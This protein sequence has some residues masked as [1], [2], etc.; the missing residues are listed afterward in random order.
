MMKGRRVLFA[1]LALIFALSM[2]LSIVM[3]LMTFFDGGKKITLEDK[4]TPQLSIDLEEL[5]SQNA[6]IRRKFEI[7]SFQKDEDGKKVFEIFS[8]KQVEDINTS[9]KNG[10]V[11]SLNTKETLFLLYDTIELFYKNDIIRITDVNGTTHEFFGVSHY[12]SSEYFDNFGGL[13]VG[14]VDMSYDINED[15]Y[16]TVKTRVE[17]LCSSFQ[18]YLDTTYLILNATRELEADELDLLC[19]RIEMIDFGWVPELEEKYA[20]LSRMPLDGFRFSN[21]RIDFFHSITQELPAVHEAFPTGSAPYEAGRYKYDRIGKVVVIEVYR[22]WSE[23]LVARIR[24]DSKND[25]DIVNEL[26]ALIKNERP[27]FERIS[28]DMP[29]LIANYRIAVYF[30]G[31]PFLHEGGR[32]RAIVFDPDGE[33]DIFAFTDGDDIFDRKE[34]Y[35][36]GGKELTDRIFKL[37]LEKIHQ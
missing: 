4:L 1:S 23:Q 30:N 27:Y 19:A 8:P 24:Y 22:K 2:T 36:T 12:S 18:G 20:E 28:G 32:D 17:I 34:Y 10:V 5:T 11:F 25:A 3:S 6:E 9:K 14:K 26:Y 33:T 16:F 29:S 35:F 15:I 13:N 37:V 31:M 7:Y 21:G